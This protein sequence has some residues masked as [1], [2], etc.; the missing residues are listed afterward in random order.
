MIKGVNSAFNAI[1]ARPS[2]RHWHRRELCLWCRSFHTSPDPDSEEDGLVVLFALCAISSSRHQPLLPLCGCVLP[3]TGRSQA[4]TACPAV[5]SLCWHAYA[6]LEHSDCHTLHDRHALLA[7]FRHRTTL[8]ALAPG[9]GHLAITRL[10]PARPSQQQHT[11]RIDSVPGCSGFCVVA[12][13]GILQL[14][15]HSTRLMIQHGSYRSRS[16]LSVFLASLP[17]PV[18][19]APQSAGKGTGAEVEAHLCRAV[20][21]N[22]SW[23]RCAGLKARRRAQFAA[24]VRVAADLDEE[25]L[26]LLLKFIPAWVKHSEYERAKCAP[27]AVQSRTPPTGVSHTHLTRHAQLEWSPALLFA[28]AIAACLRVS[29]RCTGPDRCCCAANVPCEIVCSA[30]LPRPSP[31]AEALGCQVISA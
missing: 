11:D 4:L 18:G 15:S 17:G 14:S 8:A 10:R 23:G 2:P 5:R 16:V 12:A 20:R 21:E 22:A 6:E 7:G 24:A 1:S 30:L 3:H 28:S 25:S 13:C 31:H 19:A 26:R 9:S 27:Y 29:R